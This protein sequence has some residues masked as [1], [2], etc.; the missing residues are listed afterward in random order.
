LLYQLLDEEKDVSKLRFI[1]SERPDV[2]QLINTISAASARGAKVL[3]GFAKSD[4]SIN[5]KG[6]NLP[7]GEVAARSSIADTKKKELLG[8]SGE[9][10]E[11]TLLLSQAEAL[12]YGWHL[13]EVTARNEAQPERARQLAGMGGEME[14]LYR[15]VFDMIR[16]KT[17]GAPVK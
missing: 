7:P 8:R 9:K 14:G 1:K 4:A 2:K 6:E 3:E 15:Q 16:L 13:A 12:N 10:F 5:L 17:E 11:L